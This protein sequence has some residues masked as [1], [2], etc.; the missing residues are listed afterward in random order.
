MNHKGEK[1]DC[2]EYIEIQNIERTLKCTLITNKGNKIDFESS[3]FWYFILLL[4]LLGP[5]RS[6]FFSV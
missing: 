4:V 5:L 2:K 3:L 6:F 1:S